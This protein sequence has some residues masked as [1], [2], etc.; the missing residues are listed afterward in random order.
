MG[1]STHCPETAS[2]WL[3]LHF[4]GSYSLAA[5]L[6]FS[7]LSASSGRRVKK[8]DSLLGC[9]V[10]ITQRRI[11][12][13]CAPISTQT[14]TSS[15][16]NLIGQHAQVTQITLVFLMGNR[17][18]G[19]HEENGSWSSSQEK[20]EVDSSLPPKFTEKYEVIGKLGRGSFGHVY[21][22]RDPRTKAVYAAKQVEY[23]ESNMKEVRSSD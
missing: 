15:E 20:E 6:L 13:E 18:S 22:V 14:I 19:D 3:D 4:G 2:A 17:I 7:S 10:A 11:V 5:F 8:E 16:V 9:G 12:R 23:N 1:I 21:K